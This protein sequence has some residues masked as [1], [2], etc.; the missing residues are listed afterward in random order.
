MGGD[1]DVLLAVSQTNVNQ[2]VVLVEVERTQTRA[3]DVLQV[4]QHDTLCNTLTGDEEQE[5]IIRKL[6]NREHCGD[7]FAVFQFQQVNNVHALS[8]TSGLRNLVSL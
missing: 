6:L 8:R 1:Q 2:C 3:A 4:A 5:L 7:F